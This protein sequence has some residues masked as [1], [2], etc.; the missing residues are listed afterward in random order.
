MESG[1]LDRVEPRVVADQLEILLRTRTVKAQHPHSIGEV[2]SFAATR[3]PSPRPERF[4]VGKKLKVDAMLV[5]IPGEPNACA[6]SSTIDGP[7]RRSSSTGAGRPNRCT[8]M[9]AFVRSVILRSDIGGI[10]V[11]R[12]RVD[13]GEDGDGAASRDRLGRRKE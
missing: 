13:L 7:N 11:Q 9:I 5:A 4:L 6:A 12:L 10:E 1:S 2:K 3:P 8:G